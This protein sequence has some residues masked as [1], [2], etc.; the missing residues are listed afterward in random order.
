MLNALFIGVVTV[1]GASVIGNELIA[2]NGVIHTIDQVL[3]L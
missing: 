3:L 1:D 2:D